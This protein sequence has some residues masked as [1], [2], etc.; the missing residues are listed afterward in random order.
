MILGNTQTG[1]IDFKVTFAIV[2]KIV[3]V[4]TL[5]SIAF[6]RNWPVHQMDVHNNFLYSDL[7]DEAYMRPCLAFT[8]PFLA[9]FAT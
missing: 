8:P 2:A 6:A 7:T 4:R 3:S 1:G 9:K 5:L